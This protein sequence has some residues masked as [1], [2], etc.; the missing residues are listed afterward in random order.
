MTTAEQQVL[1]GEIVEI[2]GHTNF[3]RASLVPILR[4]IKEKYRGID[5]EAMQIA[6]DVLSIHPV[7][8]DAV[9]TFYSFLDPAAQ[10]QYV[11]RLCQTYSCELAGKQEVQAELERDLGIRFGET[12]ED[13]AFSLEYRQLHG[14]VR[15]GAGH[16]RQRCDLHQADSQQSA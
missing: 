13:G 1:R 2:A 10:G 16:A 12:S 15:P 14:H 3:S 5:S 7:E 8:V 9:S 6:A 11:F 4:F